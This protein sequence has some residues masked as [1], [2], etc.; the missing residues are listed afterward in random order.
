[1]AQN[2]SGIGKDRPL[3][4]LGINE[5]EEFVY[6]WLLE[7]SGATV[8]EIAPELALSRSQMQ[9]LLNSIESK[10]LVTHTVER[11]RRYI[12]VSPDIA[13]EALVRYRREDLDRAQSMVAEL[14]KHIP[15]GRRNH[16]QD[17]ELLNSIEAERR[18]FEQMHLT[19]QEEV[20]V[21]V[22]PPIRVS[23]LEGSRDCETQRQ[24]QS[25]GVRYRSI[26]DAEWLELPGAAKRSLE[27]IRA[28]EEMRSLGTLPFKMAM[29]DRRI[30]II[31]LDY[32]GNSPSLLVRSSA[33]LNALHSL[34]EMLWERAAPVSLS[35]SDQIY[36]ESPDSE[37]PREAGELV[38]L[39]AAG[40][41]DK[42]IASELGISSST[43][44][45][46][47][48][49]LMKALDARTRFQLGWLA[50]TRLSPDR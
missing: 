26:V 1:M 9:Q 2:A 6:R 28:G 40:M 41:N 42:G 23:R 50:A 36:I 8:V 20:I 29:V 34:F 30:A 15:S 18:V 17:V 10:G 46:R 25:R 31:P 47:I 21:L 32:E 24:A 22:R 27:D 33:L 4:I 12:P 39:L 48:V 35:D 7:R 11:S 38:S 19:A 44:S 16:E 37:L 43:F 14:Q 3:S 45:R 13:I 49:E 5:K